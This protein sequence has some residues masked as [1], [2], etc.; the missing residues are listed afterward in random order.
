MANT[1][2]LS[3]RTIVRGMLGTAKTTKE[4]PVILCDGEWFAD[5]PKEAD[6]HAVVDHLNAMASAAYEVQ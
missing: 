1:Y 2:T 6:A 4:V 5:V 3:T